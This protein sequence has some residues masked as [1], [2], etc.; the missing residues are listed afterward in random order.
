MTINPDSAAD[1]ERRLRRLYAG[2]DTSAAFAP[3]LHA[4]IESLRGTETE[5]VR[6]EWR[7]RANRE[8]LETEAR[9]RRRF[10]QTLSVTLLVGAAAAIA[11]WL[12]GA[13]LGRALIALDNSHSAVRGAFGFVSLALFVGWLW[14]AVRGAARGG[15]R[16]LTFG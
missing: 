15:F 11:A 3:A 14:L 16:R 10:W 12:L 6:R 7:T 1:L 9:L 4:Q 5:Q 8:R 13:P 2:L